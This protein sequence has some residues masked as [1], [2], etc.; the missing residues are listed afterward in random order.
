MPNENLE[1]FFEFES[2]KLSL[3]EQQITLLIA[4]LERKGIITKNDAAQFSLSMAD[5]SRDLAT[6][7]STIPF[8][9]T[10]AR[11]HEEAAQRFLDLE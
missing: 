11:R 9:Q 7:P 5:L 4:L 6:H 2:F 3:Q 8:G 10:L 1:H